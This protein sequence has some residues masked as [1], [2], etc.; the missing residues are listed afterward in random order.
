MAKTDARA[1]MDNVARPIAGYLKT[2]GFKKMSHTFNRKTLDGLVQVVNLQMGRYPIGNQPELTSFNRILY[3]KF[4]VNVGVFVPELAEEWWKAQ[5]NPMAFIKEYDCQFRTRLSPLMKAAAD[6]WWDLGS[7]D[8]AVAE[9]IISN[10]R[11]Y[12]LPFLDEF[13]T[14]EQIVKGCPLFNAKST[15]H[16]LD[17]ALI[18]VG[19]GRQAEAQ[20]AFLRHVQKSAHNPGHL[21]Y[22]KG[23]ADKYGLEFS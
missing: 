12:A 23:I 7:N 20:E 9:E 2:M 3:G 5:K 17:V 1:S 19:L 13:A 16:Y 21:H 22:L 10:L 11:V 15:R 6:L 18:L 8:E 4:T 14:R